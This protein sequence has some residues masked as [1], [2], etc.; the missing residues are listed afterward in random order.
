M[1]QWSKIHT[2]CTRCETT[3][4]PHYA[5]GMCTSCYNAWHEENGPVIQE[6]DTIEDVE[7]NMA[8]LPLCLTPDTK[9]KVSKTQRVN[10]IVGA[11]AGWSLD[12]LSNEVG[13]SGR[14]VAE[15]IERHDFEIRTLSTIE[16]HKKPVYRLRL[17]Q[18]IGASA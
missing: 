8:P 1:T 17:L 18:R 5:R 10:I 12:E 7:E 2:S 13:L 11:A 16:D 6:F 4:R 15:V 3:E 9:E 14:T